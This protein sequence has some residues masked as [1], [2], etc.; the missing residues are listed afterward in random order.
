MLKKHIVLLLMAFLLAACNSGTAAPTFEVAPTQTETQAAPLPVETL[1]PTPEPSPTL[2]SA[3][4]VVRDQT[5]TVGGSELAVFGLQTR[6][7]GG[8]Q[9]LGVYAFNMT[10]NDLTPLLGVGWNLQAASPDGASLLVSRG[11][12]LYTLQVASG[13]LSLLVTDAFTWGSTAAVW[14]AD[15]SLVY[16]SGSASDVHVLRIAK[17]DSEEAAVEITGLPAQPAA[18]LPPVVN[19]QLLWA[20]GACTGLGVCTLDGAVYRTDLTTGQSVLLDGALDAALAGDGTRLAYSLRS[21]DTSTILA[22]SPSGA[23]ADGY[24]VL[25]AGEDSVSDFAWSADRLAVIMLTR[26][27]YTGR[28]YGMR[29]FMVSVADGGVQEFLETSGMLGRVYWSPDDTALLFTATDVLED[30]TW[31]IGLR[32]LNLMNG[33]WDVFDE[34]LN[35]T[36]ADFILLT[37]TFWLP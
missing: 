19:N 22:Y 29:N 10:T 15:N 36:S 4:A 17:I 24:T 23:T 37:N 27:D 16:L 1:T 6:T 21:S 33:A 14:T 35:L 12:E 34:T 30:G 32:R 5:G 13:T 8:Y 26:S 31:R 25:D 11:S 9:D 7:A 2:Q 18:L 20:S 3:P 28:T